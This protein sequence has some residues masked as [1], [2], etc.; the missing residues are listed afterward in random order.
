MNLS[1]TGPRTWLAPNAWQAFLH[2]P[3]LWYATRAAGLVALV[4]LTA[5]TA[6]GLLAA[7]RISTRRWPRFLVAGLHRNISLLALVFLALHIGT[8]VVDTYTSIGLQDALVPFLSGYHRFWLGLGA[9]ASDLLIAVS[10]TSALRSH[11]GH[12]LWRAVHWCGYLCWP[13][14]LAH[15]LGIGTDASKSW[16]FYLA[17]GCGCVVA[18]AVLARAVDLLQGRRLVQ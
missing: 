14:A 12:R 9:I 6:L 2:G 18:A 1:L 17:I 11:I 16:V 3:G 15:G 4:L 5:T 8:T 13:I 7:G 10:L